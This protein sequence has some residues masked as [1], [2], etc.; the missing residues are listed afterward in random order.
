MHGRGYDSRMNGEK[1]HYM[2]G[3]KKDVIMEEDKEKMEG[4]RKG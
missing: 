2:N 4:V 1:V 3:R